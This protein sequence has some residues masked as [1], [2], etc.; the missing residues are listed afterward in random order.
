MKLFD[1]FISYRRGAQGGPTARELYT[2]LTMKGLRVF[3]DEKEMIDGHYFTTQI[4]DNLRIAPHYILIATED[5]FQFRDGEDWVREE[6]RIAIEEY[7]KSQTSRTL[8]VLVK[9][10]F[11]FPDKKTLPEC[12]RKIA[13]VH[14]TPRKQ[15]ESQDEIFSEVFQAITKVN[16]RNLWYAAHRWLENS[17]EEGGRFAK[18]NIVERILPIA[19]EKETPLPFFST[20]VFNKED[21]KKQP[22]PLS[23]VIRSNDGNI[24]L[25]GEGGI[26]KTTALF[27]IMKE[28]Y[29][30]KLYSE[31]VQIPIFVE[32]SYAP[33]TYGRLYENGLSSFIR[34]SVFKQIRSDLTFRQVSRGQ[35]SAIQEVF[36]I[37]PDTAVKPITDAFSEITPSPEYLL[38]LDGLN[39]VSSTVVPELGCSVIKM[40]VDEIQY[41]MNQCRNVRVI[42]TSRSDQIGDY[43][44][45]VTKFTLCGVDKKTI[46]SFLANENMEEAAQNE[47][48]MKTLVNPL[49]L[50][51]YAKLHNKAGIET[52]GE[53]MRM[54]F[55]ERMGNLDIYTLH[56]RLARVE[57]DTEESGK[58]HTKVTATLLNFILDFIIPEFAWKMVQSK[59]FHIS[60]DDVGQ[61]VTKVLTD[62]S[63]SSVCGKYGKGVFVKYHEAGSVR[64]NTARIAKCMQKLDDDFEEVSGSVIDCCVYVLGLLSKDDHAFSFHQHYRDFF[65]AVRVINTMRIALYAD[66]HGDREL[67]IRAAREVLGVY[68]IDAEVCCLIGEYLGESH[69]KPKLCD[70]S[71]HYNVPCKACDRNFLDRFITIFR[72]SFEYEDG[73]CVYHII[74]ILASV[75]KNLAGMDLSDLNLCHC[76]LAGIPLGIEGLSANV[77][78]A[79]IDSKSLLPLHHRSTINGAVFDYD[80]R[81]MATFSDDQTVKI[82]D[83][84]T[85][86]LW[87]TLPHPDKVAR[88]QY[89]RDGKTLVTRLSNGMIYIWNT[90]DG[91][92]IDTIKADYFSG[93]Y[94]YN[95]KETIVYQQYG[96]LIVWNTEEKPTKLETNLDSEKL[97]NWNTRR[98]VSF[99]GEGFHACCNI[100]GSRFVAVLPGWREDRILISDIYGKIE[101]DW[102]LPN[103]H[104]SEIFINDE[105]DFIVLLSNFSIRATIIDVSAEAVIDRG[106]RI[107]FND[108]VVTEYSDGN[109]IVSLLRDDQ[110]KV[111]SVKT[112]EV[113]CQI[114]DCHD[115]ERALIDSRKNKFIG[116]DSQGDVRTW[117]LK[118]GDFIGRMGGDVERI[119]CSPTGNLLCLI[120][121]IDG[122]K[123]IRIVNADEG[124]QIQRIAGYHNGVQSCMFANP[125][126]DFLFAV[127]CYRYLRLWDLN[128]SET[129]PL[130]M[131]NQMSPDIFQ[132]YAGGKEIGLTLDDFCD[133]LYQNLTN[134][135]GEMQNLRNFV[136]TYSK[137]FL[138]ILY[139]SSTEAAAIVVR[140]YSSEML[141][142]EFPQAASSVVIGP[143]GKRLAAVF[144]KEKY[145]LIYD[146]ESGSCKC[147]IE[148]DSRLSSSA[149]FFNCEENVLYIVFF[150]LRQAELWHNAHVLMLDLN[151]GKWSRN[152]MLSGHAAYVNCICLSPDGNTLITGANDGTVK[153]WDAQTGQMLRDYRLKAKDR[154]HPVQVQ[155]IEYSPDGS[156]VAMLLDISYCKEARVIDLTTGEEICLT[157]H[158]GYITSMHFSPDGSRI[159][160]SSWDGTIKLW[161][162]ES[163]ECLDTLYNEYD[164]Q[165]R[166]LDLSE[167]IISLS[168]KDKIILRQYGVDI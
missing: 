142:I 86:R 21:E 32:L 116:I 41:L 161:D 75:R 121:K 107:P 135:F 145:I 125:D 5:A 118:T 150:E 2:F 20:N 99:T 85:G 70:G 154:F 58:Q 81:R 90:D 73:L 18:L 163:G 139:S 151:S 4:K 60:I 159:A 102:F 59:M 37:D 27:H 110:A 138:T 92:L 23:D 36:N 16:R 143:H 66:E 148:S 149:V 133:S 128:E 78:G 157:G 61:L 168:E 166:E 1:A 68:S 109:L 25:I 77:S 49:F 10:D 62:R 26:G 156:K 114:P 87:H 117:N 122:S 13:D 120:S 140:P 12:V 105:E 46:L 34:R 30:D 57:R 45:D 44:N 50:T 7:D 40:I 8:T 97:R 119:A 98:R 162:P 106:K 96:E 3:F 123:K 53:I 17:T 71:W 43:G 35:V 24:Y 152:M 64:N 54:F 83:V 130:N 141:P 160:T 158:S 55:S 22:Q 51:L 104:A 136:L 84:S 29:H 69:N 137:D 124:L 95:G 74:K 63:D 52:P 65:A 134:T 72:D 79:M 153:T 88:A 80:D 93:T 48:L 103:L 155:N 108:E 111:W 15:G 31:N 56:D 89:S 146:A 165:V 147:K 33:Q 144:P 14:R 42:L 127:D 113:I 28:A 164:L 6:M 94:C 132:Q 38:L 112:G 126:G 9:D 67:A 131:L 82:W 167:T 115:L 101:K 11:V 39:E 47:R 100:T 76:T 19:K 129:V 91:C